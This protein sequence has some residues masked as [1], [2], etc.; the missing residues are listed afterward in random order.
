MLLMRHYTSTPSERTQQNIVFRLNHHFRKPAIN[1]ANPYF[2]KLC[3]N[4]NSVLWFFFAPDRAHQ[5]NAMIVAQAC[6]GGVERD[7]SSRIQRPWKLDT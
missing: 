3:L 5:G 7:L 4:C 6:R 2:R 1:C